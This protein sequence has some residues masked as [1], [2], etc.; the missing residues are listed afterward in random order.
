M[1]SIQ[2]LHHSKAGVQWFLATLA[3]SVMVTEIKEPMNRI[4]GNDWA[5]DMPRELVQVA[6]LKIW[7]ATIV[8]HIDS[9]VA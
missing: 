5:F 2:V 7:I 9:D 8:E 1:E 4:F 3:P 6:G